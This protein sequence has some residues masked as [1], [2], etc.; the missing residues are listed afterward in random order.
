MFGPRDISRIEREFLDVL[1]FQL[2]V[3]ETDLLTLERPFISAFFSPKSRVAYTPSSP[4]NYEGGEGEDEGEEEEEEDTPS[5]WSD[6]DE[7]DE[8]TTD[9]TSSP[10]GSDRSISPKTP[11]TALGSFPILPP[12]ASDPTPKRTRKIVVP[13]PTR[14]QIH[15]PTF[16]QISVPLS[17]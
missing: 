1:D 6:S 5:R 8:A 4:T 2:R 11:S 7:E 9:F 17:V 12:P 3:T 14:H 13:Q 10:S 16:T 15:H